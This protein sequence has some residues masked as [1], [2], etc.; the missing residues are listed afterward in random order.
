MLPIAW[1]MEKIA[2]ITNIEPGTTVDSIRMARKMMFFS[3]EKAKLDLSYQYQ[4]AEEALQD[5]GM[6]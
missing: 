4:P 3:S 2:L 6:V 5:A 1:I